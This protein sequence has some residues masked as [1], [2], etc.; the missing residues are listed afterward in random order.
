MSKFFAAVALTVAFPAMAHA[1]AVAAAPKAGCCDKM[2]DMAGCMD[3]AK[4]D[5][6]DDMKAGADPHAGHVMAKPTAA[7]PTADAHQNHQ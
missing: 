4:M 3:M 7:A 2:K 1:Q 5:K 6:A